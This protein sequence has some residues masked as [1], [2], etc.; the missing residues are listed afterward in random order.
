MTDEQAIE[1]FSE[2]LQILSDRTKD[3]ERQREICVRQ[4]LDRLCISQ[5]APS[6]RDCYDAFQRIVTSSRPSDRALLCLSAFEA[7][8]V[9]EIPSYD[10][11]FPATEETPT[12]IHGKIALVRNR[13]NERAY[14]IFSKAITAAKG[15]ELPSF[16]GTCEDVFDNRCEFGILPLENTTDGRLFGF[17][18]MLDRYELRICAACH[19]E[20]ENAEGSVRYALVGKKLPS[21]IPKGVEWN[22]EC[23]IVT[24]I[25]NF[26]TDIL[27]IAPLFDAE[28]LKIDSLPLQYDDRLQKIYFTFR[29]PASKAAALHFY[30]TTEYAR[31][32]L[33]GVYPIL[34]AKA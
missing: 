5:S 30:F 33:L 11:F 32:S 17:Y 2:N 31:Y 4:L 9:G 19:L 29:L 14:Q 18:G 10:F 8:G 23:A 16:S 22:L 15:Y 24:Q 13:L 26:P 34:T 1:I 27:E 28:L 6:P 3:T 20:P 12:Q 25:G 7:S 21:R